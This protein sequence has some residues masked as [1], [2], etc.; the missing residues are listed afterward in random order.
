MAKCPISC[1]R[2]KAHTRRKAHMLSNRSLSCRAG[3]SSKAGEAGGVGNVNV[4]D[5]SA[6]DILAAA[7]TRDM[8]SGLI[9]SP[10]CR[11]GSLGSPDCRVPLRYPQ[12][13]ANCPVSC[14]RRKAQIWTNRLL[15]CR[16]GSSNKD[17]S[18]NTNG[19]GN[20][21]SSSEKS[22]DENAMGESKLRL[23]EPVREIR[24]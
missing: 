18:G 7:S 13:K 23:S 6:V 5:T 2:R 10:S 22:D 8:L 16:A 20:S 24:R 12:V 17:E 3:S 15:L 21:K 14:S 4:D 1:S 9:F 19:A 11:T